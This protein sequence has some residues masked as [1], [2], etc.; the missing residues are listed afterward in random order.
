VRNAGYEEGD[1]I[2]LFGFS[3]GAFTVRM[4]AGLIA[5]RGVCT[6]YN[7][8][9]DLRKRARQQFIAYR[10]RY[11]RGLVH[12]LWRM[13]RGRG[14]TQQLNERKVIDKIEFIG[15]WDTVDAYGFPV[16]EL[17]WLWD[18]LIWPLRFVDQRLS[19]KVKRACHALS[20]DD[21]R[22][23]FWPV[24]WDEAG[25]EACGREGEGNPQQGDDREG[26]G[27]KPRIEQVW[28]AGVHS[29]VGGGYARSELAL[30]SL[31]WMISKVEA[32]SVNDPRLRFVSR[33]RKDYAQRANCH[34]AQHD[35]RSGLRAYYRYRPR[36]IRQLCCEQGI[37]R[38]QVH[39]SV[40]KRVRKKIVAYAPTALPNTRDVVDDQ[41]GKYDC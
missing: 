39:C 40:L 31:D 21:E 29:D 16:Y 12:R 38:P 28:F 27:R 26:E 8:E 25:P 13:L 2:Y 37:A 7:D 22:A 19:Q 18:L 35:S 32:R 10:S 9:D 34:G 4:L 30:G 24:L 5:C 1:R 14:D 11:K 6:A 15:A 23:S 33:I 36:H 20:I 17:V 3:R 41:G